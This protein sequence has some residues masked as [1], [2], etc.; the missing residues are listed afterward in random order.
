M[1]T[2]NQSGETEHDIGEGR[3]RSYSQENL[4]NDQSELIETRSAMSHGFAL[5]QY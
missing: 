3:P 1:V 4:R 5:S 2:F